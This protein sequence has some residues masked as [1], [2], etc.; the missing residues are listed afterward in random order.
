MT[1]PAKYGHVDIKTIQELWQQ[2][3]YMPKET[4][5]EDFLLEKLGY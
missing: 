3:Q 5:W 4:V 2:Y 1:I